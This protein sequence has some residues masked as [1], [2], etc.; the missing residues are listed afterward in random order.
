MDIL[1]HHRTQ[2]TGAEGVHIAYIIKGF[3][4]LGFNVHVVSPNG[5]DPVKTA[6]SNPYTK[7]RGFSSNL[8]TTLSRS[9]FMEMTKRNYVGQNDALALGLK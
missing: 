4:D 7:K 6:G 5:A 3:R 8:L 2:G 9:L 1:Y